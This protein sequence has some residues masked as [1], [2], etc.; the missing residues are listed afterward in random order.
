MMEYKAISEESKK[1]LKMDKELMDLKADREW[2]KQECQKHDVE[3]EWWQHHYESLKK[4]KND[5]YQEKAF[6]ED[7]IK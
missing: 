5:W 2:Y 4:N 1:K 7:Q 3:C 6:I